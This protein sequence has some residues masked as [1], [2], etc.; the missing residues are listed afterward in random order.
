M[1]NSERAD[2]TRPRCREYHATLPPGVPV[3]WYATPKGKMDAFVCL[4]VK[5]KEK[6]NLRRS[7]FLPHL[8]ATKQVE[9]IKFHRREKCHFITADEEGGGALTRE[10]P[11]AIY[12]KQRKCR[13]SS[14][15][16]HTNMRSSPPKS[17]LAYWISSLFSICQAQS[18]KPFRNEFLMWSNEAVTAKQSLLV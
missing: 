18:H 9:S 16:T 6:K 1:R 10:A 7:Y 2:E 5:T 8:S 3:W 15:P 17:T 14:P 13:V 4:E 11:A 12:T